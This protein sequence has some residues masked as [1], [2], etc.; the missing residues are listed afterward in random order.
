MAW[1]RYRAKSNSY[2]T[3]FR[4]IPDDNMATQHKIYTNTNVPHVDIPQ[5]DLLTLLFGSSEL[6]RECDLT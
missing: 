3:V 5:V 2:L 6:V 4:E 1:R